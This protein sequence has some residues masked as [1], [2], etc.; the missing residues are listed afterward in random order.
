VALLRQDQPPR[1]SSHAGKVL[2]LARIDALKGGKGK[3]CGESHIP[4][5]HKCTKNASAPNDLTKNQQNLSKWIAA[6]VS[7]AAVGGIAAILY[8]QANSKQKILQGAKLKQES[9]RARRREEH[10]AIYNYVLSSYGL[11]RK[12][13]TDKKLDERDSLIKQGLD[14]WLSDATTQKGVFFRGIPGTS[15]SEWA[16]LKA[17]DRISDKAYGSFSRSRDVGTSFAESSLNGKEVPGVL[18]VARGSLARVP[19]HI[20]SRYGKSLGKTIEKEEEYLTKRNTTYSVDRV[21]SI[22]MRYSVNP[23]TG[24]EVRSSTGDKVKTIKVIFVDILGS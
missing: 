23:T 3:P 11:N 2:G 15:K 24:A 21:R 1:W 10:D 18:I 8:G 14:S 9:A 16:N 13:R 5:T 12:L 6:G 17:G 19:Y 7:A 22:Q 20:H 4:R